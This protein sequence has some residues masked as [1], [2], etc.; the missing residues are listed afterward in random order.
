M[1]TSIAHT[2]FSGR[3]RFWPAMSK[4]VP[5]STEVRRIGRPTVM[6]DGFIELHQFHGDVPLVVVHGHHQI[7]L[8]LPGPQENRIRRQRPTSWQSVGAGLLDGRR[9]LLAVLFSEQSFLARMRIQPGNGNARLLEAQ[10]PHG[11]VAELDGRPDASGGDLAAGF[12]ERQVG[13]DVDGAQPLAGQ[14]HAHFRVAT[15]RGNELSVPWH[16][17]PPPIGP[18]ACE[19]DR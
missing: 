2:M 10:Q 11:L 4:A 7:E 1:A 8:A 18:R 15:E 6:F 19:W 17:H 9:N 3:A 16:F 12:V 14:Q 5:W 13:R